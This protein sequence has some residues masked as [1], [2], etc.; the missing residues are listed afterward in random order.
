[1][2]NCMEKSILLYFLNNNNLIQNQHNMIRFHFLGVLTLLS[3]T[4]SA[5]VKMRPVEELINTK[6]P[7]WELVKEWV[8][9]AKNKVEVLPVDAAKAKITLFNT[10]VTTRSPM[11][12]IIYSSGGLL[13]DDGWIRILGSGHNKLNRTISDWNKGKTFEKYGEAP[14]FLLIADDAVGGFYALNGGSLGKDLGNIYF[15]SPNTLEWEPLGITYTDF[16]NFCFNGNIDSFYEGLRWKNWKKE[17]V[18][19]DG[20]KVYNF[21]PPLWTKEG[22]D[23]N[24]CS[25]KPVPVE[26]QYGLNM[27]FLK[28][29]DGNIKH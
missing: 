11:G 27:D 24:K 10:Q 14:S 18:N 17:V 13:I 28:Q 19:L 22:K 7:G 29:S 5:Q 4:I 2:K 21:Y 20:N 23:I 6:E 9:K 1:M 3:F 8:S 25:R 26:E 16:L 12:A 15:L